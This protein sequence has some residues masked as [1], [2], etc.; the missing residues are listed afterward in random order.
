VKI[1][2][3]FILY[4]TT[5]KTPHKGAKNQGENKMD[6]DFINLCYKYGN[7]IFDSA[8]HCQITQYQNSFNDYNWYDMSRYGQMM[9]NDCEN[10][11]QEANSIEGL[12]NLSP[13][14]QQ[15]RG[16]WGVWVNHCGI[17]GYFY[18]SCANNYLNNLYQQAQEEL[19]IANTIFA[20][21]LDRFN[22]FLNTFIQNV[23][24]AN[25]RPPINVPSGFV[26][27]QPPT[28]STTG[29]PTPPPIISDPNKIIT[30]LQSIAQS[31]G[32]NLNTGCCDLRNTQ[33]AN[34]I[35]DLLSNKFAE[36]TRVQI[37]VQINT[38][39]YCPPN[40]LNLAADVSANLNICDPSK[41]G[42]GGFLGSAVGQVCNPGIKVGVSFNG[43]P[44]QVSQIEICADF[45][46]PINRQCI[47]VAEITQIIEILG[48]A[49]G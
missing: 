45:P 34:R 32:C 42:L 4:Q 7:P 31:A 1:T 3:V 14:F 11:K 26:P 10:C 17:A 21:I 41:I 18:E 8:Y 35:T 49:L 24:G 37:G 46:Q 5:N 13:N 25:A 36:L 47:S 6:Q 16:D 19:N 40:N 43:D 39:Q 2:N 12:N 22:Q 44:S 23:P 28:T 33:L 48:E 9:L 29:P 27:V 38:L 30:N 20:V 15:M